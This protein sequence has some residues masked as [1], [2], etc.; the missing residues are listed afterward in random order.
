MSLGAI[1][2]GLIVDSSV[3]IVEN[4]VRRLAHEGGTRPK[5]EIVRDAAAEVLRPSLFGVLIIAIVYLPILALQG[6]EG[7]LFRPMA[8]TVIFALAGSL[9]LSLTFMPVMASLVLSEPSQ[10]EGYLADPRASSGSTPRCSTCSS[11]IPSS[12]WPWREG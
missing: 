3:I 12:P 2:F 11:T 5:Q 1:D 4:C 8:L 9:V 6:T 7:K 10:R